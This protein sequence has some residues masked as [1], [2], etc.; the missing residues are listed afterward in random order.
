[1]TKN[2]FKNKAQWNKKLHKHIKTHLKN[3]Q[4]I[5]ATV[6]IT[7]VILE[8]IYYAHKVMKCLIHYPKKCCF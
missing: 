3:E 4:K 5:K 8:Y 2:K 7:K 6:W 1:M